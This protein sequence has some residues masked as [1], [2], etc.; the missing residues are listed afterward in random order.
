MQ[1]QTKS[2]K[3]S[4]TEFDATAK[5]PSLSL[6]EE[7]MRAYT[8]D[9]S[10]N[11]SDR[12]VF[13]NG[14]WWTQQGQIV[15]PN[16]RLVRARIISEYHDSAMAGH[17]GIQRTLE[18][19]QRRFW[20]RSMALDVD[21]Y[22]RTCDACQCHKASSLKKAGRLQ[23][24]SIPYG[25][26]ESVSMDLIVKLPK[27]AS[28]PSYD[29]I[30]VF[31]DRLSKMV[32]LVP[33]NE[34]VTSKD[35]VDLFFTHVV[36]KHGMPKE[37]ISDRGP[38]FIGSFWAE[39]C[40]RLQIEKKTTTAYHPETNGQ[41]ERMNRVVEEALRSYI[42][43]EQDDWHT[44]LPMIEF[45]INNSWQA[46]IDNTPFYMVY[47]K[48]PLMPA[49]VNIPEKNPAASRFI[50]K[51]ET[52][53]KSA[54]KHWATV[55]QKMKAREDVHRR[56]LEIKVGDLVLLNTANIRRNN[57]DGIRKLMPRW[58]GPFPVK[59]MKGEVNVQ[60]EL[61]KEWNRMHDVFHISLVKPY[62]QREGDN[63]TPDA[64]PPPPIDWLDNEPLW[65]V[66][67]IVGHERSGTGRR[68]NI[69]F[70]VRWKG[71]G[72]EHDTLEPR[73]N[74]MGSELGPMV[75]AYKLANHLPLDKY[76]DK[77]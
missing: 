39:V 11:P 46:S 4:R 36:S 76:D 48:H 15:V 68:Q 28:Q 12:W 56:T 44:W 57:K 23:P 7:V 3:R 51:M 10:F 24:L 38:H 41:T 62:Q 30:L 1:V 43:S 34:S 9:T 47:G 13:K 49:E 70:L 77:Y 42:N 75:R 58:I 74:L 19:V 65:E 50:R 61:P 64:K 37:V 52:V 55:Q 32:H 31:V 71:Y 66:E 21:R 69:K 6:D 5:E 2:K 59:A 63:V 8:V 16:S 35:M 72:P 73:K 22:V 45:A 18:K 26:W 25:V 53:I 67:S 54:R 29:S 20:W 33:T 40:N 27:T 17:P 60:L 14:L